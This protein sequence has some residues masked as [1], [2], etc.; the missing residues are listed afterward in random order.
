M[1]TKAPRASLA[2]AL[3]RRYTPW[4]FVLAGL[5]AIPGVVYWIAADRSVVELPY[6]Q[7]K[8]RLMRKEIQSLKVGTTELTGVLRPAAQ[9]AVRSGSTRR[10][11][12]WRRMRDWPGCLM[13]T[14]PTA[15]TRPGTVR[16]SPRRCWPRCY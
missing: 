14:F 8:Q 15:P 2:H 6:G 4:L 7:F 9:G 13:K 10:G 1:D 11:W 12:G 5:L 16:H 3:R